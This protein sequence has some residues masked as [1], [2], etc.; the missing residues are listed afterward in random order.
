MKSVYYQKLYDKLLKHYMTTRT[1]PRK[2]GVV[3]YLTEKELED[4]LYLW[5][6]KAVKEWGF[7]MMAV[8]KESII[9]FFKKLL[10]RI[11]FLGLIF[12]FIILSM[13]SVENNQPILSLISSIL[14]GFFVLLMYVKG[15]L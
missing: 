8:K 15:L 11:F 1:A 2:T 4:L 6:H 9:T 3:L 13:F 10:A 7:R 12:S 5:A 14:A